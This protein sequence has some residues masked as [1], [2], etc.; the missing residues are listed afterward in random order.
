MDRLRKFVWATPGIFAEDIMTS[1]IIGVNFPKYSRYYRSHPL[2]SRNIPEIKYSRIFR[3][4]FFRNILNIREMLSSKYPEY[5]GK[6][7]WN[8]TIEISGYF[9]KMVRAL[10]EAVMSSRYRF[11]AYICL[12]IVILAEILRPSSEICLRPKCFLVDRV[13]ACAYNN[14]IYG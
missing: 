8:A 13:F 12:S 11:G 10:S 9:G 6:M 3:G 14:C 7:V 2:F 4:P 5:L 1:L